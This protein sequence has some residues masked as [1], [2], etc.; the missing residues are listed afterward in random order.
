MTDW[1]NHQHF[2]ELWQNLIQLHAIRNH[3]IRTPTVSTFGIQYPKS[4]TMVIREISATDAPRLIFFTDIRSPKCSEITK[5]N[6]VTVHVYDVQ[7]QQQIQFFT[8]GSIHQNHPQ[9]TK[10]AQIGLQR[11]MDYAT[12]LSPSTP[13]ESEHVHKNLLLAPKHFVVLIC[14][15]TMVEILKIGTPHKR[16]HWT[17][18]EDSWTRRWLVP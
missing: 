12:T 8:T 9:S 17:L 18:S 4:R 1:T 6:S 2:S 11:P 7:N 15:V 14:T 16:C 3:P 5:N 13:L 10:W